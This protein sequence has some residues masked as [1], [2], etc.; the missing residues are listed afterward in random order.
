MQFG[1]SK[2]NNK[3]TDENSGPGEHVLELE[4]DWG[5]CARLKVALVVLHSDNKREPL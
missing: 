1:V 2:D 4:R 3:H 5:K